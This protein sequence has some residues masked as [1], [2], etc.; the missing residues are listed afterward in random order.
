MCFSGIAFGEGRFILPNPFHLCYRLPSVLLWPWEL[1]FWPLVKG[2]LA[3]KE[4]LSWAL[5]FQNKLFRSVFSTSKYIEYT[6]KEQ[7]TLLL[8]GELSTGQS[9][10][11]VKQLT[12][13]LPLS[14]SISRVPLS[15]EIFPNDSRF[16]Y[17]RKRPSLPMNQAKASLEAN[18]GLSS[19][20]LASNL[21]SFTLFLYF[22]RSVGYCS[23]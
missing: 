21:L 6:T 3:S 13:W 12:T 1:F 16:V 5:F 18:F 20:E 7:K 8:E 11:H 10:T 15:G 14:S 23:P 22:L 2:R 17:T 4:Q 19:P 9:T